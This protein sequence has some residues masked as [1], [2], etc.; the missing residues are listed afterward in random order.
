MWYE[1]RDLE[2]YFSLFSK[3]GFNC[4]KKASKFQILSVSTGEKSYFCEFVWVQKQKIQYK[5]KKEFSLILIILYMC[6]TSVISI[7]PELKHNIL[8]FGYGVNF[9][10]VGIL[11]HSFDR[12][13]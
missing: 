3:K 11:S 6:G 13:M 5:G 4:I 12:F 7:M 2:N 9:R 1:Y 8:R 10:Y